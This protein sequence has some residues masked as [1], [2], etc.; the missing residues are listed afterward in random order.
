MSEYIDLIKKEKQEALQDF[1]EHVLRSGL[2]R[3]I[4]EETKPSRLNVNWFRRPAIAGSSV[5]LIIFLGWLIAQFFQPS[6]QLTEASRI[7]NTFVQLFT[8]QETMLS[9]SFQP[10]DI[11]SNGSE[12]DEFEWTVKRVIYAIQREKSVGVDI[13]ENLKR[14]LQSAA[15]LLVTKNENDEKQNI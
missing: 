5:L 9:Q 8:Q 10:V 4:T 6:S 1:N 2:D 15:A 11:G 3:R 14:V 13:S 7:K 12:N